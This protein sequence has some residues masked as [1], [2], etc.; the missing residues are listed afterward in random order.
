MLLTQ[1]GFETFR[2][3]PWLHFETML[4]TP[5]PAGRHGDDGSNASG[6][7]RGLQ[8]LVIRTRI[9]R[10]KELTTGDPEDAKER[11]VSDHARGAPTE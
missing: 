4:Q 3:S 11:R 10:T 2:P 8:W 7:R 9:I 5:G 6:G 1:S